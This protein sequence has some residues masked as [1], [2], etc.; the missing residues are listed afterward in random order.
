MHLSGITRYPIKGLNG[1]TLSRV[2]LKRGQG[3]PGDRQ[4]AFGVDASKDDGTWYASPS[5]LINSR[6]DNLLKHSQ[7]RDGETWELNSPTGQVLRFDANDA[8]SVKQVNTQLRSFL[9]AVDNEGRTPCLIARN[10]E[11]G[12][13]G[14]WD[15]P[16]TE[17]LVLNL[18]TLRDLERQW[19][20]AI[21]PHR[22]RANLLIDGLP[23]WA[24]FGFYGAEFA[25]GAAKIT[26]LRP[27]R[28]CAAL[29]V[30]PTTGERDVALHNDLVRDYGHGFMGAYA[31]VTQSG[32]IALED[33][34]TRADTK[35]LP[36][37]DMT[38][39]SAPNVSLW[40]KIATI[41][42]TTDP[43]FFELSAT[44][45]LPLAET[46]AKGRM[47]LHLG[48]NSVLNAQIVD[49]SRDYMRVRLEQNSLLK[50]PSETVIVSGPYASKTPAIE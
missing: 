11:Q 48:P 24:E 18:A 9:S 38:C 23:A 37:A 39:D 13:K 16:D 1:D 7:K 10:L 17:V 32:E 2:T 42:P 19:G 15:F 36:A 47:K 26:F 31:R 5:Y 29:A 34:I 20:I 30:S 46:D 6:R 25:I 22:F 3:V 50:E 49:A 21:D 35:I 44:G 8:D 40:P 12:P 43:E 45:A 28:R 33:E 27:A 4:F 14:H 41:K